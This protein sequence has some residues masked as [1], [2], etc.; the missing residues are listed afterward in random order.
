L[1]NSISIVRE[2]EKRH[3]GKGGKRK[4]EFP[5]TQKKYMGV[6]KKGRS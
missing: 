4:K 3:A 5:I 2:G 6:V 1:E